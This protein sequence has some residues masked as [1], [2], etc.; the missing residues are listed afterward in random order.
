ME[1]KQEWL[2]AIDARTSRRTYSDEKMKPDTVK[3]IQSLVDLCNRESGLSIRFVDNGAEA[4]QSFSSSYGMFHGVQSYFAVAG[5]KKLPHL[6]ELAGYF[7]ELIVLEC[8]AKGLGTCWVSGTFD[9]EVCQKQSGLTN[10][11]ELLCIIPVGCVGKQKTLKE[12]AIGLVGRKTKKQEDFIESS[13]ALPEWVTKGIEA[14]TKAPSAMNKQPFHFTYKA[15]TV[16]AQ[17]ADRSS[18]QGIDLGIARTHFELGAWG[19]KF[20]GNWVLQNDEYIF[21][22]VE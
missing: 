1:M 7:G 21:Q 14:V 4:F 18:Y 13:T 22:R 15:G 17:V 16:T 11:E 8:T 12:K 2:R 5:N 10:E 3:Q 6:Q 9:K 20:K 19:A